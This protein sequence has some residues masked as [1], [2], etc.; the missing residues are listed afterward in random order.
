MRPLLQEPMPAPA[1]RYRKLVEKPYR[2]CR[3]R[4]LEGQFADLLLIAEIM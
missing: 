1:V 3:L 2:E 4:S